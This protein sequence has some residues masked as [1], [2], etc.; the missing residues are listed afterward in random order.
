MN[1]R[2][3]ILDYIT[4]VL[5]LFGFTMIILMSFS[6]LFG[7]SAKGYTNLFAAG[8][9]GIP[10]AIMAQFLVL[11]VINVFIRFIFLSDRLIKEMVISIR[12]SLTLIAVL[13]SI[14]VFIIIFGWF[15][16]YMWQPWALFVGSFLLCS[17]IGTFVTTAQNKLENKKLAEGLANLREQWGSGNGTED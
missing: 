15:P 12:I 11:S 1:D 8:K 17:A 7:E 4:Q 10:A 5:G 16:I 6:M 13:I 14:S 9:A 2:K 3:T